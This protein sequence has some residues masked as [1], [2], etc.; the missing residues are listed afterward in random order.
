VVF[1]KVFDK[2][3]IEGLYSSLINVD[4]T[5]PEISLE[6]PLDGMR[7]VGPVFISGQTTDGIDLRNVTIQIRSL[8][9]GKV[10]SDISLI[11]MEADDILAKGVELGNLDNGIYN[12]DVS[13][14]DAAG[15][16]TRVSR[17]VI[18]DKTVTRNRVETLYPLNG[19][20]LQG[21]FV[22]YGKVQATDKA[23]NVTLYIDGKEAELS[24]VTDTGY[25][26]FKL[27]P[28]KLV[29]GN[30]VLA[31][32]SSFGTNMLV[33]SAPLSVI[34]KS[35]GPWVTIDNLVMGDFAFERPWLSGSAGYVLSAEELAL[36]DAKETDKEVK[37]ELEMKK[38]QSI[39]ISFDNGR[40]FREVEMKKDGWKYRIETQDMPQGYHF[41]L[42][43][44][45]MGDGTKA[46]TRTIIQIDKTAPVIR[47][48]SPGEGG[49][50]NQEIEFAG[51]ASDDINLAFVNYHLRKGDKSAYEV[52][53]FIQGLYFDLHFWGATL[54]DVGLGLTFFDDNVKL[55]IQYGQFTESQ[56]A[57]FMDEPF[58]YGGNV[59]GAKLLANL[60]YLPISYFEGPDW[61]WLSATMALGAN[62]SIFS[63]TQSGK[64]QMLSAVLAQIEFPRVT[65]A[66]RKSFR[67]FSAYTEVQ[68]WFIPTDVS[69]SEVDIQSVV[70]HVT[71]GF[72]A[73]VF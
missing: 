27:T 51:L 41:M 28:E 29:D 72:R 30:H 61:S 57:M 50:Y 71:F 63:E 67:T 55:Q 48:I 15:N 32:K 59:Y 60:L 25:Y 22:L 17:N 21:T 3:G 40:S 31:V 39:Q 11:K 33:S 53:G 58:R 5:A 14:E 18:L 34:Y 52:P 35:T 12:I 47:L 65:F 8:N 43:R 62:F 9:G 36:L 23:D 44:A 19:Q 69:S 73:N 26:S 4:N 13:G 20:H 66:K 10:P 16:I 38:V 64:S 49:R 42:V 45:N 54:Y 2:Y 6:L 46:I 37:S 1:V 24:P 56:W 7:T 68:M 70:P